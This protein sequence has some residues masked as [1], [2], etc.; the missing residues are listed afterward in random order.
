VIGEDRAQQRFAGTV[1]VDGGGVEEVDAGLNGGKN[2]FDGIQL[3]AFAPVRIRDNAPAAETQLRNR[4]VGVGE[5][6][7]FMTCVLFP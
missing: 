4:E 6:V 3:V 2:R 1:S 7:V 5:C